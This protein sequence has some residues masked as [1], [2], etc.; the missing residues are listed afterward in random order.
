MPIDASI[1]SGLK[2]PENNAL[3]TVGKLQDIQRGI[4]G[5][6]QL[7]LE[8]GATQAQ[9]RAVTKN[10][11]DGV[12][13]WDHAAADLSLDPQGAWK[14]GDFAAQ[15]LKRKADQIALETAKA[16]LTQ[17]ELATSQKKFA[18]VGDWAAMMAAAGAKD[19]TVLANPKALITSAGTGLINTGII[20]P[21]NP[22][23]RDQFLSVMAQFGNDPK[24]NL[25]ILKQTYLQ[26]HATSEGIGLV[27]GSPSTLDTGGGIQ[28][29][30]VSPLT[31]QV[32][33]LGTTPKTLTP[34]E[35]AALVSVQNETTG[36]TGLVPRGSMGDQPGGGAAPAG[37]GRYP[38]RPANAGGIPGAVAVSKLA[39]GTPENM[40]ASAATYQ[41]D[42]KAVP[43]LRRTLTGFDEA[44][45]AVKAAPTGRGSDV[46][47]NL[48]ALADT[49][50]VPLPKGW[51]D[52][53]KNYQEANKWLSTILTT[54]SQRLGLGT[55][56]AR[57]LQG[58]AQPSTH[59]V[60]AAALEML[61]ILKGM[62]AMDMAFP[63][64]A[65]RQG[66]APQQYVEW[67]GA[68]ARAVDPIAFGADLMP[69]A[70]RIAY[71]AG[72]NT[73]EKKA[74]YIKGLKLAMDAGLFSQDALK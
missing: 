64:L 2:V 15:V 68:Q 16:G 25:E 66:I 23:E 28:T 74:R 6:R 49:Y 45:R 26:G 20:N 46:M 10:T 5:N 7:G 51:D 65:Q 18:A 67:R 62:K 69:K 70:E 19:P 29:R 59:T 50:N 61:P 35:Q 36:T 58:E 13:D 39:P 42:T 33:D 43:N 73:P 55:D 54:E 52:E 40:A 32:T 14:A 8:I 34:A 53:A 21:A 72:L 11:K 71:M 24:K 56:Q 60:K 30:Q 9:G 12:T 1:I 57:A 4:L 44:Y 41:E 22:Q 37:T 17:A 31:G 38:A 48:K 27:L 3:E 63:T 47:Q